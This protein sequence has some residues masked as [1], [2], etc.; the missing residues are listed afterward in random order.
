MFPAR[1]RAHGKFQLNRWG[2][3]SDKTTGMQVSLKLMV[4]PKSDASSD[5][6]V[7]NNCMRRGEVK[8]C[9]EIE[10]IEGPYGC[11]GGLRAHSRP[12]RTVPGEGCPGRRP[13]P[14][15][16]EGTGPSA[17]IGASP[18]LRRSRTWLQDKLWSDPRT[19]TGRR[20]L[21]PVPSGN[22]LRFAGA[23][24]LLPDRVGLDCPR[25]APTL[26]LVNT[27]RPDRNGGGDVEFLEGIDIR[28]PEFENWLRDQRAF[29]FQS[30]DRSHDVEV[31]RPV[32]QEIL[33]GS[34]LGAGRPR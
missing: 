10:A 13:D 23:S 5:G 8:H 22:T 1:G 31:E 34:F 4:S 33:P 14:E 3:A 27:P 29:Y 30:S 26:A 25:S 9:S 19:G 11:K 15:V 20:Q 18:R 2:S 6:S 24:H 28:D 21:A 12:R 32:P 17:S 16:P 7:T